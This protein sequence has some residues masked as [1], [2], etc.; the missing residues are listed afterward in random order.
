[1]ISEMIFIL[2]FLLAMMRFVS[3]ATAQNTNSLASGPAKESPAREIS[4]KRLLKVR[5]S[6]T[7]H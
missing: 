6:I 3:S 5:I 2:F 1:M 7:G 4:L